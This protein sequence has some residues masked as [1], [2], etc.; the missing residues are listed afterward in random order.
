MHHDF[1]G[2]PNDMVVRHDVIA[3]GDAKTR[4]RTD[5]KQVLLR[6]VVV[7]ERIPEYLNAIK[8]VRIGR[9]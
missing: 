4:S 6:G 1:L 2:V 7:L 3:R 8:N 9:L 5:G